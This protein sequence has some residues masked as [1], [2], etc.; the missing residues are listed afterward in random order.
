MSFINN[1]F[2]AIAGQTTSLARNPG[3]DFIPVDN[4]G[5]TIQIKGDNVAWLGMRSRYT[6]KYAYDFCYPLSSVVDR[7]AEYDLT[8]EVE[9]LRSKGKG[10]ENYATGSW[11]TNLNKRFKAPN[12]LQSWEQFRGQQV[13]YK[14]VF[15]FCPVL[16]IVPTGFTPDNVV[17]M[18]NLPPWM[19]DVV[20]A[21]NFNLLS[22]SLQDM[23][24][25]YTLTI[26]GETIK[27]Q[28]EWVIILEDS[29]MQ[30]ENS[31]FLLPQ[32][33]LVGLDMA[34]S[35]ICAAMEADN[36]LLRKRGPLGFISH[37]NTKDA[38]GHIP[39]EPDDK[40]E[41]QDDLQKYGLSLS[42]FLYVISKAPAR[43]NP[44]SYDT[45]QLGTKETVVAGEEAICHRFGFP[46]ILYKESD[47]TFAN[48]AQAATAVYFNNVI[49]N[50][51]KDA[52]KYNMFFRAEENASKIVFCYDDVPFLQDDVKTA[53]EARKAQNES[54][55]ME[56]DNNLITLNQW[57]EKMEYDTVPGDD[58]Y[59]RDINKSTEPVP[60][61][62]GV[63]VNKLI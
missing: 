37:E 48:G 19:F 34:I 7:L 27:L 63:S 35:N 25:H 1:L 11:A 14:R 23:I 17:A 24:K 13:V 46:Y 6:Q 29:F 51:K 20:P 47:A 39:M 38:I 58:V 61:P 40:K 32:S 49:P 18:I 52:S 15:G 16:P 31:K 4:A 28:P 22:S 43:W 10:K 57:R 33:R 5:N 12:P 8:G 9:I 53:A 45:K 2:G 60:L 44:M 59:K 42:Q 41:L 56:Y 50:A 55:L 62:T 26:F 21:D 36:V 3:M 30:D 54:H